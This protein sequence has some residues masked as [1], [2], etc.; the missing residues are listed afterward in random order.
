MIKFERHPDIALNLAEWNKGGFKAMYAK[1]Y[2]AGFA[3][4]AS[5]EWTER[6][7]LRTLF[8]RDLWFLV[9]HGLGIKQANHPFWV[10]MCS[11]VENGPP[12]DTLDIWARFHGK[13]SI[14]TIGETFQFQV[15]NP[16]K[17]TGIFCYARPAAKK[18]LRALKTLLEESDLL[19][20]CFD[21]VLWQKPEVE[22]P[23]W[24]E[25]DGLVLKR[26]GSS[27]K[28]SSIEAWGLTEGMPT[29]S[30]FERIV[31]D[32]LE[33]E[34]IRESPDMLAKVFSKFQMAAVNLGT[35]SDTD[36]TRIIGT[37]Y[38]HF[39]PNV[40]I[41]DMKFDDGRPVYN[42]RLVP[43]SIDGTRE[44]QPVLMDAKVWERAK[45]S[46]HFNSQQLCNP[47]PDYE[48]KLDFAMLQPIEPRFMP[49]NRLKFV[50]IDPAGDDAQTKGVKN[51]SWAMGCISV[52][53]V[54]DDLGT[55]KIFIEDAVCDSMSLNVAVDA[56]VGLYLRNGRIT[57]VGIERVGT[58]S[59]YEHVRKALLAKG[60]Y[61]KIKKTER[62]DGNMI[63][64]SP[65]G[66]SKTRRIESALSWP[67]NNGKIY[68][69]TRL[70]SSILD[71]LR[72]EC[73]K[74]PL[75]HVDFLDMIAY[76][77]KVIELMRFNFRCQD[78]DTDDEDETLTGRGGGHLSLL[79]GKSAVTGY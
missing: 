77:Y 53:P 31:F 25:D 69:S 64:L 30:H 32:D 76:V 78:E 52:E 38:S 34:D 63:L 35:G 79:Q 3:K 47:T 24:S 56:A 2:L 48:I 71:K 61:V 46:P 72:E 28:E 41:G 20:W 21:D 23:K 26:S 1:D 44:G 39:G 17:C 10:K 14:L 66:K 67:W 73:A 12:S 13:S 54:M 43:G 15:N 57:G 75:Y 40:K 37:Y 59:A 58:D 68:Y 45:M 50:L 65:D 6:S 51:D 27:R 19:K 18:P 4:V 42:L 36:Q 16:E 74:F 60:R 62:D 7:F 11:E 22:A 33:T 8:G 9:C 70:P 5:G 55:S 29:G 49:K